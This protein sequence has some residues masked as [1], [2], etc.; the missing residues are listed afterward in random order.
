MSKKILAFI[1]LA[2]FINFLISCSTTRTFS[3]NKVIETAPS[4]K[5]KA[6]KLPEILLITINK[7][8]HKGK[9]LSLEGENLLLSPFP[10]WNVKPIEIGLNEIYSIK[11]MK[12]GSK[13]GKGFLWGLSLG[14]ILEGGVSLTGGELKYDRDYKNALSASVARG[15]FGGLLGLAIGGISSI[16]KKSKYN[17]S[18]MSKIDKIIAIKEI[19]GV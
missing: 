11:V 4:I 3:R 8:V 7:K 9:I 18:K 1:T 12:K 14:F 2:L 5:I 15:L 13:S 10:Y 16:G 17:F 6:E 19:M